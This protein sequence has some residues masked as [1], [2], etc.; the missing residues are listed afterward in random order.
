MQIKKVIKLTIKWRLK[1]TYNYLD[2][3][4]KNI[5]KLLDKKD[6]F[7]NYFKEYKQNFIGF[8]TIYQYIQKI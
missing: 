8:M 2:T 5:Y 7:Q 3:F 4:N 6:N 1:E